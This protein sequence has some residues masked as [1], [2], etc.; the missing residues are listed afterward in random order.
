[1]NEVSGMSFTY[2][3][4]TISA[5]PA[6]MSRIIRMKLRFILIRLLSKV[7]LLHTTLNPQLTS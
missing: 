5:A 1:M 2:T 4:I 7:V 6:K 3:N